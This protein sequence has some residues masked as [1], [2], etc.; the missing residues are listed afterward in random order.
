[1]RSNITFHIRYELHRNNNNEI[2]RD[3]KIRQKT[4][5]PIKLIFHIQT[6]IDVRKDINNILSEIVILKI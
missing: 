6:H 1:M 5:K 2:E 3:I 4:I